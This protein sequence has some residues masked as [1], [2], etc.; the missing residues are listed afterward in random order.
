MVK[1]VLFSSGEWKGYKVNLLKRNKRLWSISVYNNFSFN[2]DTI[3]D[4][5]LIKSCDE[6]KSDIREYKL[7]KIFNGE[8]N[9]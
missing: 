8:N 5:E 2:H 1:C 3:T 9:K 4:D 7:K 6:I